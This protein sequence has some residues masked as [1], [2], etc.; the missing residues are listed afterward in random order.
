MKKCLL[1]GG[2]T[3]DVRR[4]NG[5]SHGD[6]INKIINTTNYILGQI[7]GYFKRA[8]FPMP[9]HNILE[10]S[11]MSDVGIDD[12]LYFSLQTHRKRTK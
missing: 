11:D 9:L 8:E 12:S 4:E 2:L 10:T 6:R 1:S 5:V 7:F 3:R